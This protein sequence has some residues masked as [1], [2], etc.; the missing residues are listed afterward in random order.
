MKL[1]WHCSNGEPHSY[2]TLWQMRN[3]DPAVVIYNNICRYGYD[4]AY[5]Y[6][7]SGSGEELCTYVTPHNMLM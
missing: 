4:G 1:S 6:R 5:V 3:L 7:S 2:D